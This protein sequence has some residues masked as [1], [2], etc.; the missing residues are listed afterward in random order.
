MEP[1][2]IA[3]IGLG[4]VGLPLAQALS[5]KHKTIGFDINTAQENDTCRFGVDE[6][7]LFYDLCIKIRDNILQNIKE[8]LD[9][10]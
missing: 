5:T 3:V 2:N 9:E 7:S 4:Y 8:R 10:R 1:L 6:I